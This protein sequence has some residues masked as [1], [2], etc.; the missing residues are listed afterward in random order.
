MLSAAD[1]AL[2]CAPRRAERRRVVRGS[3]RR[4]RVAGVASGP[5]TRSQR[6]RYAERMRHGLKPSQGRCAAQAAPSGRAC[7]AAAARSGANRGQEAVA[8]RS[9]FGDLEVPKCIASTATLRVD[10]GPI[11]GFL[12]VSHD[13]GL[14]C[15]LE[16]WYRQGSSRSVTLEREFSALPAGTALA[17][18]SASGNCTRSSCRSL[19]RRQ[20]Y[21]TTEP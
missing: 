13:G 18:G 3:R 15:D 1:T 4:E 21:P 19:S 16:T 11:L 7:G 9:H 12:L 20:S 8:E 2:R 17:G 5:W 10:V 14:G 6:R